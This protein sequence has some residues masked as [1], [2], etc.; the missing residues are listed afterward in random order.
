MPKPLTAQQ[1]LQKMQQYCAYQERCHAE[2]VQKLKTFGIFAAEKDEI[3]TKLIEDDFLNE[4]R[5]ASA[6]VRGKHRIKHWGR[7]RLTNELKLRGV[8][9]R[10]VDFALRQIDD[11]KYQIGFARLAD[12][13]WDELSSESIL[14]RKKKCGDYLLRKGYESDLVFGYLAAR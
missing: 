6:F 1:A 13:C 7:I 12:N 8:S 11:E 5:F 10:N 4:E 9:K 2:V 14:K 3:I